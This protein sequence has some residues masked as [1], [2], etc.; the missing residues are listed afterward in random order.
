MTVYPAI[1]LFI[2][3]HNIFESTKFSVLC[4]PFELHPLRNYRRSKQVQKN[5]K[6]NVTSVRGRRH[7]YCVSKFF[8]SEMKKKITGLVIINSQGANVKR[9]GL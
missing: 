8:T 3:N 6:R 4:I 9:N 2:R 7:A 1:I 5:N